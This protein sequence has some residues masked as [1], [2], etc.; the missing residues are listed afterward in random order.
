ML[1]EHAK[2]K[3]GVFVG[4]G[5]I[6][7]QAENLGLH[8]PPLC[9]TLIPRTSVTVVPD[10]IE[11]LSTVSILDRSFHARPDKSARIII[12]QAEQYRPLTRI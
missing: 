4:D 2:G 11:Q 8:K 6:G 9:D 3:Q 7:K 12:C 1:R 5:P 10:F